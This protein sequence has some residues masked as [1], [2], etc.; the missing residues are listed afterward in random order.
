[1]DILG[2]LRNV[3]GRLK[4]H[5]KLEFLCGLCIKRS[6]LLRITSRNVIGRDAINVVFVI[7]MGQSNISFFLTLL[8]SSFGI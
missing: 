3:S 2:I 7:K 8:L 1:M 5:L 4:Y 6:Y